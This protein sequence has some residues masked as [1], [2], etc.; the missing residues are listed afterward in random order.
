[1][2]ADKLQ[3]M[4]LPLDGFWLPKA[5]STLAPVVDDPFWIIY[6][7][8][9]IAF[10]LMMAPMFWFAWAYRRKTKDQKAVS[11]VD[12]S[13]A[14][15]IAWSVLPLIFFFWVF[16]IGFRGFLE[17]Y[18]APSGATEVQVTGQKWQWSITYTTNT[19]DKVVVGGPGA[20]FVFPKGKKFKLVMKSQDVLHSFFVP[21][22]RIKSDVIPGRYTTLWFEATEAG[23]F[24][25]LC[26][27]YCGKDHSNMLGKIK[28]VETEQEFTDW[29]EKQKVTVVNAESGKALFEQKGCTACHSVDGTKLVGPSMKGLWER[30]EKTSAG[31]VKVDAEYITE[32]I[33][34]PQAKIV[35]GYPPA[36]PPFQGQLNQDQINA[37]IEYIKVLK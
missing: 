20:E 28:I 15:E 12:H 31:E 24:P 1:M 32:S 8:C 30:T 9:V 10:F 29:L 23:V 26:T 22:F 19:G 33:W 16:V 34:Q 6:W 37:I 7:A 2:D 4:H 35:E 21:N 25:L 36:M 3:A 13:Q 11:Q 5:T 18:V 17:I 27:E 14:M